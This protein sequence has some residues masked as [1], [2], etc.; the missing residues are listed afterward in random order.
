MTEVKVDPRAFDMN[1]KDRSRRQSVLALAQQPSQLSDDT[2]ESQRSNQAMTTGLLN[3]IVA[4]C[5]KLQ[6][7]TI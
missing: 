6:K 7:R 2:G 4:K 5:D 1:G 3:T